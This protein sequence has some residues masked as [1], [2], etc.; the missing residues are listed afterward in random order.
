[1]WKTSGNTFAELRIT[2]AYIRLFLVPESSGGERMVPLARVGNYEIRMFEVS[3][4][5]RLDLPSLWMELYAHDSQSAIDSCICE[6]FDAAVTT[7]ENMI[8]QA[9]EL[10]ELSRRKEE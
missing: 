2:R 1:V 6:E 7:A 3:Q 8:L 5:D 10:H 4:A 9:R